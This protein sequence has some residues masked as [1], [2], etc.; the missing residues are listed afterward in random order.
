[1]PPVPDDSEAAAKASAKEFLKEVKDQL[2]DEVETLD[3]WQPKVMD[4]KD[5]PIILDCYADWCAPCRKVTPMLEKKTI[6]NDGKFKLVKLNIENIPQLTKGLNV[7]AVPS[8]FLI[9]RGNVMDTLTGADQAKIDGMVETA[10]LIEKTS[11]DET[12]MVKVLKEA[13]N[14]IEQGHY[15]NA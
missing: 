9:Y 7:K 5:K 2:I 14:M 1:M 11:H 12:I 10:L 4:V 3:Q 15:K 13:E 6:E 8:L